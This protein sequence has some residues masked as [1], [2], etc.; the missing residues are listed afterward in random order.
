METNGLEVDWKEVAF[1][2]SGAN[3][4]LTK[5]IQKLDREYEKLWTQHKKLK[6]LVIIT[7]K[8]LSG[9]N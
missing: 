9:N 2:L 6:D 4:V 8:G 5:K 1:L 7:D 3:E